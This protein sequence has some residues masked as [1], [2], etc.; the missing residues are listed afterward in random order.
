MT[1]YTIAVLQK[2]T[3]NAAIKIKTLLEKSG[4]T[5]VYLYENQLPKTQT[6]INWKLPETGYPDILIIT[7]EYCSIADSEQHGH[8]RMVLETALKAGIT[9]IA[10]MPETKSA[11]NSDFLHGHITYE[12]PEETLNTV[13]A[14]AVRISSLEREKI[15]LSEKNKTQ[16]KHIREIDERLQMVA[17]STESIGDFSHIDQLAVRLLE[18]FARNMAASGG[19]IFLHSEGNLI[20]KHSIDPGHAPAKIKCPPPENSVLYKAVTKGKPVFVE[21]IS[22]HPE[23]ASSGWKGYKGSSLLVFPLT[24]SDELAGVIT[25]HN[26]EGPIFTKEDLE[27]GRIL[28]HYSNK[29]L[30]ALD[31]MEQLRKAE[32]LYKRFFEND[33]TADFTADKNGVIYECNKEFL[34]IFEFQSKQQALSCRFSEF[35][36]SKKMFNEIVTHLKKHTDRAFY[37]ELKLNTANGNT[38]Y[39]IAN[40]IGEYKA[41]AQSKNGIEEPAKVSKL[42]NIS[43]YL[44]DITGRKHLEEQLIQTQKME[45]LGR[46]S[47]GVAHDFNNLITAIIGYSELLLDSIPKNEETHSD[48]L[49]IKQAAERGSQ[50]T[51]QLLSFTRKPEGE[52]STDPL[53]QILSGMQNLLQRLINA[54]INI[55]LELTEKNYPVAV[56]KTKLEQVIMNLVI[57]ARDAIL[58]T[59]QKGTIHICTTYI[60]IKDPARLY[61]EE[62]KAAPYM[63]L[64]IAD[65]GDGMNAEVQKHIF[66]P[67]YSNKKNTSSGTGMGLSTVYNIVTQVGG[68]IEVES[69]PHQGTSFVIFLPICSAKAKNVTADTKKINI[70]DKKETGHTVLIAEDDENIKT[71]IKRILNNHGYSVIDIQPYINDTNLLKTHAEGSHVLIT[72]IVMP[73]INGLELHKCLTAY[74]SKLKTIFIS[75]YEKP[76]S[77][78]DKYGENETIFLRKPFSADEIISNVETIL[79]KE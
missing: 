36:L 78:T 43:G 3:S 20:R 71:L 6:S 28:S 45:A 60:P 1:N 27:L 26:K 22:A 47:S 12:M 31:S 54:N 55:D 14:Q 11:R 5:V 8:I 15:K 39:V 29:V 63:R 23:L 13:I 48:I 42:Q 56:P 62:L 19:S 53:N 61:R 2:R 37:K 79:K 68:S 10:I 74:N 65:T 44:L 17:D 35:F 75:G 76:A 33:I 46:L 30:S 73:D 41:A 34:R 49:E 51:A 38:I 72:D 69:I 66:E 9:I 77:L 70:P 59:S 16:Q 18:D 21:D 7:E 57:N 52:I 50:M 64:E 25:L 32:E 4:H 58:Q 24:A 67:F 40:F